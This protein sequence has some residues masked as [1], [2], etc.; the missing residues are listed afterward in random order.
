MSTSQTESPLHTSDNHISHKMEIN[1]QGCWCDEK[2]AARGCQLQPSLI[3]Q[4]GISNNDI[5]SHLWCQKWQLN[6]TDMLSATHYP[7]LLT[8]AWQR[9]M[10]PHAGLR[11][12]GVCSAVGTA[13]SHRGGSHIPYSILIFTF[14]KM[15]YL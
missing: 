11:P 2:I 10:K 14:S 9:L 8:R 6:L 12:L 3:S 15:Q 1:L 5:S 4:E 13:S 7:Y